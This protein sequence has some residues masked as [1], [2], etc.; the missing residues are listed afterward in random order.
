[1]RL[2]C[3]L[4]AVGPT[5]DT[6]L[7]DEAGRVVARRRL[8]D[9]AAGLT[10][11]VAALVEHA[12]PDPVLAEVA[13]SGP[14]GVLVTGLRLAG[15]R[16]VVVDL[17]S[18]PGSAHLASGASTDPARP[19]PSVLADVVR[20]DGVGQKALPRLPEQDGTLGALVRTHR[21]VVEARQCDVT[22]LRALLRDFFPAA[23]SAFPDLTGG[24]CLAVLA[25]APSPVE[26]AGLSREVVLGLLADAGA[27]RY[28]M[29]ADRLVATLRASWARRA[30]PVERACAAVVRDTVAALQAT[31][32]TLETLER[33]LT[34]L[35]AEQVPVLV[36]TGPA[37][38]GVGSGAGGSVGGRPPAADDAP[39]RAVRRAARHQR[40]PGSSPDA[41]ADRGT[42]D[43]TGG[44]GAAE[45]G[46]A[47]G[48]A[49][50]G[51]PAGRATVSRTAAGAGV[52]RSSV[53]DAFPVRA[54]GNG[55]NGL[56]VRNGSTPSGPLRAVAPERDRQPPW[57]TD[58]LESP[59]APAGSD[60]DDLLIFASIESEWF[61]RHPLD[62][63]TPLAPGAEPEPP[64]WV[65]AAD[66]GWR[67]AEQATRPVVAG[68]TRSGLPV[69]TPRANLVPGAALPRRSAEPRHVRLDPELVRTR[70][71]GYHGGFDRGAELGDGLADGSDLLGPGGTA[72]RG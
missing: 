65:T 43:G 61:R 55:A 6:V 9:D 36:S 42:A 68:R 26:A 35:L 13:A 69:R 60:T 53:Y 58:L 66:E 44:A 25:A 31:A 49:A 50:A 19:D 37:V 41:G 40:R 16:L 2:F 56:G 67:A 14:Q 15:H 32:R 1:M 72:G 18:V 52:S 70:L 24:P 62:T 10:A 51:I 29:D 11:L 8:E 47:S 30:E 12:G 20:I 34:A 46:A 23:L 21:A 5:A 54:A 57:R 38:V 45:N 17:A 59:L 33:S 4:A 27:T 48:V 3:G 39:D 71:A 22:A 28:P 64:D 63:A 7:V